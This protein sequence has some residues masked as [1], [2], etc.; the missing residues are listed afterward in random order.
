[1]TTARYSTVHLHNFKFIFTEYVWLK[2]KINF[3]LILILSVPSE[4]SS[5]I[6]KL[7]VKMTLLIWDAYTAMHDWG[8]AKGS[9][10]V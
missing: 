2:D 1:M 9:I 5:N 4:L 10:S 7:T 6:C 3:K 8:G